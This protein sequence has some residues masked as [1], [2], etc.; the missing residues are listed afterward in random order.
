MYCMYIY[1]TALWCPLWHSTNWAKCLFKFWRV[2]RISFCQPISFALHPV[3]QS[4]RGKA[5]ARQIHPSQCCRVMSPRIARRK[6]SNIE[7]SAL[8]GRM[9]PCFAVI[10]IKQKGRYETLKTVKMLCCRR[11]KGRRVSVKSPSPFCL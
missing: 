11:L 4:A 5:R 9:V 6:F 10:P 8:Q 3:V 7:P 2:N 1:G